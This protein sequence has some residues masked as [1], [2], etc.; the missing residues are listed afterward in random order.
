[1]NAFEKKVAAFDAFKR[2]TAR[3]TP[4]AWEDAA[5]FFNDAY[6]RP[7]DPKAPKV[8]K[9]K[10]GKMVYPFPIA[11]AM[12]ADSEVVEMGFWTE[13]GL[14]LDFERAERI[15][16]IGAS[17]VPRG[18]AR[19]TSDLAHSSLPEI[20]PTRSP[21]RQFREDR[22]SKEKPPVFHRGTV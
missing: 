18:E 4:Q 13:R 6:T 1:M 19:T 12:F 14:P 10:R 11:V 21:R 2:A 3:N 5:R 7:K 16:R 9:F 22:Q 8:R 20:L 15:C 17:E